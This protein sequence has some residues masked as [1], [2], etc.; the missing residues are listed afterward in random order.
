M[1]RRLVKAKVRY[2][3]AIKGGP[4][5][6]L[7][8]GY[9]HATLP[10]SAYIAVGFGDAHVSKNGKIVWREEPSAK[11]WPRVRRFELMAR[12]AHRRQDWRIVMDGPLHGETWQRQGKNHWVLVE[13]NQGFA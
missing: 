10:L 3:P 2:L 8:C 11:R 5:G 12:R 9:A 7:N 4:A 13:R 1:K 6:C